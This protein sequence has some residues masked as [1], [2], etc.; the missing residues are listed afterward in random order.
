MFGLIVVTVSF[1]EELVDS[2]IANSW[3]LNVGFVP[4]NNAEQGIP[5]IGTKTLGRS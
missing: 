4:L 3:I 5:A 1:T 2:E